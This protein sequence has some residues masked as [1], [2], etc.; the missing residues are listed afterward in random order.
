MDRRETGGCAMT[1]SVV[2][3][4][5]NT[6]VWREEHPNREAAIRA[7]RELSERNYNADY[8]KFYVDSEEIRV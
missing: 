8:F 4:A 5:K 1:V 7:V 6:V 3:I 2:D